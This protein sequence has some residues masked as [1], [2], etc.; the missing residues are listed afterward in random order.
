MRVRVDVS[1]DCCD[2]CPFLVYTHEEDL[3][4]LSDECREYPSAFNNI[5]VDCPLKH[6]N[7]IKYSNVEVIS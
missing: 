1:T 3:C 7:K 6:K 2:D 4:V 5:P